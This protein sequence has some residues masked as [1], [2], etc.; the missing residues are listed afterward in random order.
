MNDFFDF[1]LLKK[2]KSLLIFFIILF[3][4]MTINSQARESELLVESVYS[5]EIPYVQQAVRY[6]LRL[7]RDSHLQ[8]GY[9]LTPD[10][11]DTILLEDEENEIR[12]V[13]RNGREYE[14]LEQKYFLIPQKSGEIKLPEPVF[15]S[16]KLFVKGETLTLKVKPRP[17]NFPRKKWLIAKAIHIEQKW[18][19]PEHPL[20]T[21]E[22]LERTIIISGVGIIGAQLPKI[23]L[24]D[25]GFLISENGSISSAE[26]ALTVQ[27]FFDNSHHS[28]NNGELY[29][30]RTQKIRYIAAKPGN[31]SIPDIT[32]FWFNSES[33]EI[34]EELIPG[35]LISVEQ[36]L[37]LNDHK[38]YVKP[39]K[40]SRE[41]L[42]YYEVFY[43]EILSKFK[44]IERDTIYT[45]LIFTA[46]IFLLFLLQK[47]YR[48][49]NN[50]FN[51]IQM[52]F[53]SRVLKTYHIYKLQ[54]RLK[55]ACKQSDYFQIKT[56]LLEWAKV[57]F[58]E[59]S[60]LNLV[61]LSSMTQS[62]TIIESLSQIDRSLY[63]ISSMKT[64]DSKTRS[65]L[66]NFMRTANKPKIHDNKLL[67][68]PQMWQRQ[69]GR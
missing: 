45:M 41:T 2:R 33:G 15:S 66:V 43:S 26:D 49:L 35:R 39:E 36:G 23:Q 5:P 37:I 53:Q 10:I 17:Q 24:I 52:L 47:K 59:H 69:S 60:I 30:Q 27:D 46:I 1:I 56:I 11:P 7:W 62:K 3:F 48:Q 58:P 14:V 65:V 34:K 40:N 16:R 51:L 20:Q 29:G 63:G 61:S 55:K 44:N 42:F 54:L 32:V 67:Q 18:M 31:Y 38:I 22:P 50:V 57:Q 9:F 68:L 6:T 21:G 19:I 64:I 8:Q 4:S 13:K 25:K 12:Q 28:V